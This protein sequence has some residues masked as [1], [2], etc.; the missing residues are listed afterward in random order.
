MRQRSLTTQRLWKTD[1]MGLWQ[2]KAE[3]ATWNK[4]R[5]WLDWTRKSFS[6]CSAMVSLQILDKKTLRVGGE[7]DDIIMIT[8]GL[9]TQILPLSLPSLPQACS[10]VISAQV[11]LDRIIT[12]ASFSNSDL[13]TS[14]IRAIKNSYQC[15][16][17]IRLTTNPDNLFHSRTIQLKFWGN[18]L[19]YVF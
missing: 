19:E 3:A 17:C 10:W 11:N 2:S 5:V 13:L 15:Q 18:T 12:E 4:H 16:T 6:P 8:K 7:K 1:K 9:T 14:C